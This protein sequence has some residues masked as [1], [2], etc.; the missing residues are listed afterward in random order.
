[1][2]NLIE[3]FDAEVSGWLIVASS[4]ELLIPVERVR[5]VDE[6]THGV[7]QIAIRGQLLCNSRAINATR[8][9]PRDVLVPAP[10][11]GCAA[12][13]V[14]HNHP[15]G[16]AEPSRADRVVTIALREVCTLIGT[17]LLDHI[18]VTGDGYWSFRD[19][20]SWQD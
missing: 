11:V 20:G 1:L 3:A 7:R 15:S 5:L 12:I 9:T 8:F 2:K 4:Q 13:G 10:Q 18:I 16:E 14:A 6:P 19:A 17:P